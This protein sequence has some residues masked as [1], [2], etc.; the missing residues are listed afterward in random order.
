VV[1]G[2]PLSMILLEVFYRHVLRQSR[3]V[4]SGKPL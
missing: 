2:K 1:S 3:H 4:V